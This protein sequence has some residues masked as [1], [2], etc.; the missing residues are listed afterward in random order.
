MMRALAHAKIN[1]RHR[2]FARDETGFHGVETLLLRTSLADEVSIEESQAGISIEVD[3]PLSAGVPE[4]PEN[5]CCLAA[6]KFFERAYAP[7]K[8]RPGIHIRLT[9]RIPTASGLGGGSADA[10]AT[11]RLLATRWGNATDRD[12]IAISGELGSDITFGVLGVPMALGWE[13]GRRL[14]PLRGPRPRSA[15][16]LSPPIAVSTPAAYQWLRAGRTVQETSAETPDVGSAAVLPGSTRMT[17]WETLERMAGNDLEA[18]VFKNHPE[19]GVALDNLRALDPGCAGMTG[20]GS[21]LFA[22]FQDQAS[23]AEA[24][25]KIGSLVSD[26]WNLE[27]VELPV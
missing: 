25:Q 12:L 1:L 14:L 6:E 16:L 22:V 8:T 19:L 21:T 26:D 3:G 10:A 9:K 4:G 11:L 20:S 27:E 17:Q 5:L 18:P 15:L 13:R 23:C 24:S 2:V 7:R